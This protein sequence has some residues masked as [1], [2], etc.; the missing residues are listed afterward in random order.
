MIVVGEKFDIIIQ[1]FGDSRKFKMMVECIHVS[2]QVLRFKI[3][4]GQKEMIMEKLLIKK[5]NPW[6]IAKMNFQFEGDDKNIAMAIMNIQDRI[7]YYINPPTKPNWY[8]S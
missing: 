6:K 5:T 4:G 3:T 1:R 8:K 7:E 2:D